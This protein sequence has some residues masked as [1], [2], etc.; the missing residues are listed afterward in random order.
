MCQTTKHAAWCTAILKR[1]EAL[2]YR[3]IEPPNKLKILHHTDE[4]FLSILLLVLHDNA[5]DS[6]VSIERDR[7]RKENFGIVWIELTRLDGPAIGARDLRKMCSRA[8]VVVLELVWVV[9]E[10]LQGD[11][12]LR[13]NRLQP[14][15][16]SFC[17]ACAVVDDEDIALV[18]VR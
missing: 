3:T 11:S 7:A 9:V 18:E 8:A 13:A 16:Q 15:C 12:V 14:C 10:M 5:F 4:S 1:H 2:D 17:E 6:A